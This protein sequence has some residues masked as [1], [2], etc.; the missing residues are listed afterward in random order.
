MKNFSVKNINF[1]GAGAALLAFIFTFIPFY[2]LQPTTYFLQNESTAALYTITKNLV[3]YNFFGVLCLILALAAII[4]YVWNGSEKITMAA[5]VVSVV[6][7]I[8][9]FLALIVGNS[10]IKDKKYFNLCHKHFLV[11]N[12]INSC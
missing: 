10:D 6:D 7:L 5:I 1:V 8:S 9:L 3:T 4:L 11:F 2:K 12:V